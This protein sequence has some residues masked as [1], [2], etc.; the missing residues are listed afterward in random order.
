MGELI[1]HH[2]HLMHLNR[3]SFLHVLVLYYHFIIHYIINIAIFK[4]YL[5]VFTS[6]ALVLNRDQ[7]LLLLTPVKPKRT[8]AG[9]NIFPVLITCLHFQLKR[10]ETDRLSVSSEW[11]AFSFK[12][13]QGKYRSLTI[14]RQAAIVI[15]TDFQ[16]CY[17]FL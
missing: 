2:R 14:Y 8:K 4:T 17:I 7:L 15:H 11:S 1:K 13:A 6:L 5:S 16:N 12:I 3:H 10:G 9:W